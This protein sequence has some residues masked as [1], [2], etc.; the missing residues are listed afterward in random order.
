[1]ERD[2]LKDA[3][4][5]SHFRDPG[6][7]RRAWTPASSPQFRQQAVQR[8]LNMEILEAE[9]AAQLL[10]DLGARGFLA[11]HLDYA[12]PELRQAVAVLA[13]LRLGRRL[14]VPRYRHFEIEGERTVERPRP[15][16]RAATA[17]VI[18]QRR[19]SVANGEH[20]AHG[21]DAMV[22]EIGHDVAIGVR[23]AEVM[24]LHALAAQIQP[25]AVFERDVRGTRLIGL[26]HLAPR[27]LRG[28]D[29]NVLR[30]HL[31]IPAAVVAVI[32]RVDHVAHRLVRQ[33]ADLR[34]Q[35]VEVDLE[36]VVDED[37]ALIRDENR[38]VAGNQV[39]VDDEEVVPDL[40]R[41][42][43]GRLVAELGVDVGTEE[44][45]G[46]RDDETQAGSHT[47]R[48]L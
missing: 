47:A 23:A 38:R 2:A 5:G 4:P 18:D 6:H 25:H 40:D 28:D 43:R 29:L 41:R 42:Q 14:A 44:N 11:L 8:R 27:T 35:V 13:Q 9:S 34:H 22:W 24:D 33:L 30:L 37:Q 7:K 17:R 3:T 32:M 10:L 26:D 46:Q 20:V 48:I 16:T 36:L 12:P 19:Q 39:V 31:R 45:D 15:L 1:M 21:H